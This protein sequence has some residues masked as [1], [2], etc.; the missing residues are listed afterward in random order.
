MKKRIF[1]ALMAAALLAGSVS[2]ASAFSS[3]LD[4]FNTK[5]G[6]A[7]TVLNT[8]GLC[9]TNPAGGGAR[10]SFGSDFANAS[11]GNHTFNATLEARDSDGDT[12]SNI[13][14]IN[15][16]T[17]PGDAASKPAP[18]PPPPPPADTTPPSVS[19][20]AP[21]NGA[22]VSGTVTISA[23]ASDNVGVTGVQFK[24]DGNNVGAQDTTS[25]YSVAWNTTT[26]T[27]GSHTITAVAS[28]A[29]GNTATSAAVIVTVS[30][31]TP[32]P[33]P[34]PPVDGTMPLPTGEDTFTYDPVVSPVVSTLPA[35][36]KPIGVGPVANG[37]DVVDIAVSLAQFAGPVDVFFGIYAS[38]RPMDVFFL[39]SEYRLR[40]LSEAAVEFDRSVRSDGPDDAKKKKK[41]KKRLLWK[42]KVKDVNEAL[43]IDVP[44]SDLPK[45]QYTLILQV[46][47]SEVDDG[48][49]ADNGE[50]EDE[51]EGFYRW[52]TSFR[53][54]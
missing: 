4:S 9:H 45:G 52:V 27:N 23:N 38:V 7:G 31:A 51:E 32:P 10:N 2:I 16:R 5:Y 39:D 29:A 40:P 33:P 46:E 21:A 19:L 47:P 24:V 20:T 50:N 49:E 14:E 34:P 48:R 3:Y 11:I 26:F 1:S 25:P 41:F 54:R 37:G 36:A 30:N 6:T 35:D 15:A 53:I 22:T 42:T 13:T 8:C 12:F 43:F 17:F 28:D 44:V 18:P